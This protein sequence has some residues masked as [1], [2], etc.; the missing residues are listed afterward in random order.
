MSSLTPGTA[1]PIPTFPSFKIVIASVAPL[2][3]TRKCI[4]AP[5]APM[6]EV[7]LRLRSEVVAVPPKIVGTVKDVSIVYAPA[8]KTPANTAAEGSPVAL[9]KTRADG[10]P[11]AGVINVGE[12]LN[13]ASPVPVSSER[14]ARS[15]AELVSVDCLAFNC[16]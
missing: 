12:S 13:T 7:V 1:V 4:S 11:S 14:A 5:A 8:P 3:P 15:P 10:V 6:P 2:L 16:V 9:V